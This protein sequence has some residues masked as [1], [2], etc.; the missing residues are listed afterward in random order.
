[1]WRKQPLTDHAV[2]AEGYFVSCL[3]ISVFVG[4]AAIKGCVPPDPSVHWPGHA[5]VHFMKRLHVIMSIGSFL[6]ELC[7]AFFAIFGLHR[8]LT[9]GF[10]TR[11]VSTAALLVRE[12]EFEFVAVTS[13][14]F[15]G[16]MLMMGPVGIHCFCMVQQ[17]L[18]SDLLA[19]SVCCLIV[20]AVLLI[21]SL[22]NEQLAHFPFDSY[23]ELM[24]RFV[25]LS[26][27]RC[28]EGGRP[29]ALMVLAWSLQGIAVLLALASLFETLP[30]RYYR[31]ETC[32]EPAGLP[33]GSPGGTHPHHPRAP[34]P[35]VGESAAEED[36]DRRRAMAPQEARP[37][38]DPRPLRHR[39]MPQTTHATHR[40][41]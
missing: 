17:G 26:F 9:G 20:G 1:M 10:D 5:W 22:F 34:S 24:G 2:E 36:Q 28:A 27:W 12:L 38:R 4:M 32:F 30:W 14:F 31:D 39:A 13:Y 37:P 18:R 29:A 40:S 35:Q 8:T 16:S 11:A 33:P 7:A 3:C 41:I 19:A 21:I 6:L 15:A 25:E 23:E